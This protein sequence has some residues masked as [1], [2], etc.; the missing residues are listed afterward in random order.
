MYICKKK[1]MGKPI[2]YPLAE[3][4]IRMVESATL[5]MTAKARALTQQGHNVINLSI[6]EPDFDT[7]QFIK[8]AAKK[9]LDEGYTK[10]TPVSGLLELRQA[11]QRKLSRDN[12]IHVDLDQIVVSNGAK[13][14]IANVCMSLL[15]EGDEVI[16]FSPY[17]VSYLEIV[18]LAGGVPVLLET[19]I[20]ND[21]KVSPKQLAD[22]ITKKTR[23]VLFSSPCNPTGTVYTLEELT[24]F[25]EILGALDEIYIVSDEIYEYINYTGHH[26]SIGS[27]PQVKDQTITING[28]SKG[29][30]MTGWRLGYIAAPKDVAKATD[31]M[32]GQ[33][34]S[35]AS[36]FGQKAAVAALDSDLS[37]TFKM[38][39]KFKERRDLMVSLLREIEGLKTNVPD[40]A[41][42]VF[43]DVSAFFGR[44]SPKGVMIA[45]ADD[46][47][48]YILE[49]AYVALVSGS[50]FG[51]DK[52]IRISYA[53]SVMEIEDACKRMKMVL[54]QLT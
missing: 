31:K 15:N 19:S 47:C 35:G 7:P 37:E 39:D 36:S 51:D 32:Q 53:A 9:A 46:L 29:F 18:Q 1:S 17:W 48:Q 13:Q 27:L 10:Y 22:A 45:D 33:F 40:G 30:S 16:I 26:A 14:S 28:F 44:K 24:K 38:R 5:Q 25:A 20:E 42:Y 2:S 34:T 23:M 4:I 43:P 12:D 41:F 11:I 54:D 52:C 50:A 6:G 3:R 49:E 21:Y 8:D